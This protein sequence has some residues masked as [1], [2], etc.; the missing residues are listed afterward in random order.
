ML[1]NFGIEGESYEMKDGYPTYTE[2]ITKNPDGLSMSASL[3]RYALSHTEGP[4]IQDKRYM[5]QYASLPQQ[6]E[7]IQIWS[8]TNM[9]KHLLPG[10]SLLPDEANAMAS[11]IENINTYQTEMVCK[12][13]MGIEPIEKFDSYVAELKNRGLD[14]YVEMMQQ[15]YNRFL[16]R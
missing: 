15:A 9:E 4:F 3:A 10:I 5:E 2:T 16:E 14:Q 12:F 11:K 13:I 7:A 8:D 6:K 1:F